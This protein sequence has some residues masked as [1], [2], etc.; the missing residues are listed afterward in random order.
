MKNDEQIR[1]LMTGLLEGQKMLDQ[2][3]DALEERYDFINANPESINKASGVLIPKDF[4]EIHER[5][6]VEGLLALHHKRLKEFSNAVL[7]MNAFKVLFS[8]PLPPE[9]EDVRAKLVQERGTVTTVG[10]AHV[11]RE[12]SKRISMLEKIRLREK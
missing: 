12:I 11:L 7:L 8:E 5:S 4:W 1:D 3:A 6:F 9:L 2:I 10:V